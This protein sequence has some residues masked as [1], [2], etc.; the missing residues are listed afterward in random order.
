MANHL[1]NNVTRLENI[2]FISKFECKLNFYLFGDY[3][4]SMKPQNIES[5]RK[6]ALDIQF[7]RTSFLLYKIN[8]EHAYLQALSFLVQ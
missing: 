6:R 4:A 1:C 5:I 8:I 2:I 3:A 7:T